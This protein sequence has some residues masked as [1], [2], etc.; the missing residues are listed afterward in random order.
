MA[1]AVGLPAR[2][3]SGVAVLPAGIFGHAWSEVW[4]GEWLAVD[5]TFGQVPASPR[6]VRATIG[7]SSGPIDLVPLLGSARFGALG[8]RHSALGTRR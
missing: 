6:L 8:T 7:G 5:P 2:A 4:T 3:V 1:R